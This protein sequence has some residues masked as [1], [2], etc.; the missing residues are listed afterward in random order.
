MTVPIINPLPSVREAFIL[1]LPGGIELRDVDPV[2]VVQP[3][4]TPLAPLFNVLEAV[5]AIFECVKAIPATFGPP[6]DP[7]ALV[8]AITDAV[9]KVARLLG[10]I[11]QLSLPRTII[12]LVDIVI[13]VLDDVV[14]TLRDLV[15]RLVLIERA[16]ERA[17]S[18]GDENLARILGVARQNV[19]RESEQLAARLGQ[20]SGI[21]GLLN[22]FLQMVGGPS[23]P[24]L[25]RPP[26][27]DLEG[28]V[29]MLEDMV[30]TLR[31]VR[32]VIPL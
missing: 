23:I 29:S 7:T 27:D 32:R 12:G 31:N 2:R 25:D 8:N 28:F 13:G 1:A 16:E 4:L 10:L 5:L 24:N 11:P 3:A 19:A 26:T 18:L 15:D 17:R 9:R 6:P 14:G 22:L 20:V 21:F 30:D